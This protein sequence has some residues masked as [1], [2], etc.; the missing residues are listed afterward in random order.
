MTNYTLG[1]ELAMNIIVVLIVLLLIL[2]IG[3]VKLGVEKKGILKGSLVGFFVFIIIPICAYLVFFPV[4]FS[5]INLLNQDVLNVSFWKEEIS[6]GVFAIRIASLV[7]TIK[8]IVT[9][10]ALV[11]QNNVFEKRLEVDCANETEL[12][13][14]IEK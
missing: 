9:L 8:F 4:I 7:L 3:V 13:N 11:K 6:T 10:I 14:N 12:I 1:H 2:S 5:S